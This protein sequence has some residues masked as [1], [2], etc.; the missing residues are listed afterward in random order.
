[1]RFA[2]LK[3]TRRIIARRGWGVYTTHSHSEGRGGW[4]PSHIR[5]WNALSHTIIL[6]TTVSWCPGI[7]NGISHCQLDE[8]TNRTTDTQHFQ[9]SDAIFLVCCLCPTVEACVFSLRQFR[10]YAESRGRVRLL[11]WLSLFF[12]CYVVLFAPNSFWAAVITIWP[13]ISFN[14]SMAS[15]SN[16]CFSIAVALSFS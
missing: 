4:V 13:I 14:P 10:L 9:R 11:A 5:V 16:C 1:M 8:T 2:V 7:Q 15:N 12:L 6:A 3:H